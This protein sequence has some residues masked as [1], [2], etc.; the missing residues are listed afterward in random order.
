MDLL[1]HAGQVKVLAPPSLRQ[2]YAERL[3]QAVAAL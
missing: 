2:A 3:K 1:R